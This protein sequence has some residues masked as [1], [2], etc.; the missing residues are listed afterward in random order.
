MFVHDVFVRA[1]GERD[2]GDARFVVDDERAGAFEEFRRIRLLKLE[3]R[4]VDDEVRVLM[5][6]K[7]DDVL[8]SLPSA[9]LVLHREKF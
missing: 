6:Q 8:S 1:L 5:L 3:E 9:I 4:V 7:L 2:E